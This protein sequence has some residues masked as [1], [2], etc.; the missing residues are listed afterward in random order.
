MGLRSSW[1]TILHSIPSRRN[2]YLM[3]SRSLY[4]HGATEP[5]MRTGFNTVLCLLALPSCVSTA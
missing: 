3:I 5:K 1:Y 2:V 4:N